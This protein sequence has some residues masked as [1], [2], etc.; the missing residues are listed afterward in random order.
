MSRDE[1]R[2]PAVAT[3]GDRGRIT[4][5]NRSHGG[6]PKHQ[7]REARVT[8]SGLEGDRQRN[9]KHH[10]GPD[11]ALC[12]YSEELIAA[13]REEGHP[14]APGSVGENVTVF[15]IDWR[16]MTPGTRIALGEVII[17]VTSYTAPC[18]TIRESFDAER[19]TRISEKSHPGWSRVYARVLVEGLL[20]SGDE[21]RLLPRYAE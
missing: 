12:L 7:V 21:V 2:L 11:R 4:S 14:I 20:R 16:L 19:F 15:G 5:I 17:E 9:L 8:R 3:E 13:L 10:G 1:V 18:R 6:V